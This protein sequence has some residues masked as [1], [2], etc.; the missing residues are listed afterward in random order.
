MVPPNV[1]E[2]PPGS[3]ERPQHAPQASWPLAHS[4]PG[5]ASTPQ[6]TAHAFAEPEQLTKQS[7]SHLISQLDVS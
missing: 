5:V 1:M 7:P 2:E 6:V 3:L 4:M